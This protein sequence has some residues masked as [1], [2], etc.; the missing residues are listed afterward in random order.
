LKFLAKEKGGISLQFL[1]HFCY[2]IGRPYPY[3]E[4]DMVRLDRKRE[5]VPSFLFALCFKKLLTAVLEFADKNRLASFGTPDEMIDNEMDSVL[6]P[7]VFKLAFLC[8]FH[9]R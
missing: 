4:M 3:K 7:P 5:N 2:T 1:D 9:S 6:I 8:R